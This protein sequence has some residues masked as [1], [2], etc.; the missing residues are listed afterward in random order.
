M[1]KMNTMTFRILL[2]IL[3]GGG[4]IVAGTCG[5]GYIALQRY[6]ERV[7]QD[8]VRRL[9]ETAS[10]RFEIAAR[11]ILR[12]AESF[13]KYEGFSSQWILYS[14]SVESRK[15]DE[16]LGDILLDSPYLSCVGLLLDP[17]TWQRTREE[18]MH[19]PF[20]IRSG[21][22]FLLRDLAETETDYLDAAFFINVMAEKR[23]RWV[24]P[25]AALGDD[26]MAAGYAY[27]LEHGVV[28]LGVSS[29]WVADVMQGAGAPLGGTI[30][31]RTSEGREIFRSAS[32]A[33]DEAEIA[34]A[35]A[36][37]LMGWT[38]EVA[39]PARVITG[40]ARDF[41]VKTLVIGG[42]ALISTLLLVALVT[43]SAARSLQNLKKNITLLAES[44]DGFSLSPTGVAGVEIDELTESFEAVHLNV[45]KRIAD[46]ERV[47]VAREGE[48]KELEIAADLRKKF[49]AP[50]V[51]EEARYS[52]VTRLDCSSRLRGVFYDVLPTDRGTVYLTVGEVPGEGAASTLSLCAVLSFLRA[53]LISSGPKPN[54]AMTQLGELLARFDVDGGGVSMLLAEFYPSTGIC[55]FANANYPNAMV[56]RGEESAMIDLPEGAKVGTGGEDY[57]NVIINMSKGDFI[58]LYSA[59]LVDGN[60]KPL[61]AE[62]LSICAATAVQGKTSCSD[63]LEALVRE[64]S[65]GSETRAV[66]ADDVLMLLQYQ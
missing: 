19:A 52:I 37:P 53:V 25:M 43:T 24:E 64:L 8:V 5:Y 14:E 12:R 16:H 2:I 57:A 28:L 39:Y 36:L 15:L 42:L 18:V 46:A 23:A 63:V 54:N 66:T 6:S 41:A 44:S 3:L 35:S 29:E 13:E 7:A 32:A 40:A 31:I 48:R 1:K 27:P 59:D 26:H 45:A 56:V 21:D 10:V 30:R 4:L 33:R 50:P 11:P 61:S 47:L 65:G 38:F 58:L 60:G 51:F 62:Q 34:Y 9:S 22:A 49:F 20:A 17:A 55:V